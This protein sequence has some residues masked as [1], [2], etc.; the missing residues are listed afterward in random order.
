MKVV[1]TSFKRSSYQVELYNSLLFESALG[2][3]AATYP[4]LHAALDKPQSYW[5]HLRTST[6]IE[7]RRELDFCQ[8]QQTWKML[9]QLLHAQSFA[10]VEDFFTFIQALEDKDFNFLILPYLGNCQ[11][12]NRLRAAQGDLEA[13]QSMIQACEEHLFFPQMIRTVC[14]IGAKEL[15]RHLTDMLR[16][17]EEEIGGVDAE[18]K[19]E[20]LERDLSMKRNWLRTCTPEEVVLRASGIEYKP[21]SSVSKVLLIPHVIYRPWTVEADMEDTRIFYYPVSDASMQSNGDPYEP[22]GQLVQ[23]YKALGDDKRLRALKLISEQDRSLKELTD[24]LNM[25]KTTVHHHLAILRG[26]GLVR[27]KDGSYSWNPGSLNQHDQELR[28][29][30]GLGDGSR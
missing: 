4:K 17:W 13:A 22:P 26:A 18:E 10:S 12:N 5:Q 25:G 11:E 28:D 7:L 20:I 27:V 21:E 15:K 1:D 8:R 9:L 29:F 14:E 30:L 24:L 23:L 16:L 3:A 2:I 6:S 19:K